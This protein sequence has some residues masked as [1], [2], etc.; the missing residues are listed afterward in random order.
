MESFTYLLQMLSKGEL[1]PCYVGKQNENFFKNIYK[2]TLPC[3]SIYYYNL[4]NH[5]AEW[6]KQYPK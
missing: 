5:M 2:T 4:L 6:K 3:K 1:F